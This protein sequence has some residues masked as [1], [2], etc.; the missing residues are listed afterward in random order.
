VFT[1]AGALE[2]SGHPALGQDFGAVLGGGKA[3]GVRVSDDAAAALRAGD[4]LI[5][6][7]QPQPTLEHLRLAR[8]A[9]KPVVIGTTGLSEQERGA[10]ADAAT[11]IPVVFS[12]NMSVGVNLLFELAQIAAQ[13]LGLAYDVEV[14][15]AHHKHKK[16][17]PSGTAKRLAE[18]VA[19]ARRQPVDKIPVHAIR[20]GDIVG[21]HTAIF[22]G[23][24]ERLELTHRASSRDVFAL[25]A[26]KA[27]QFIV[28]Q[29]SG[30]YDM[31]HV[32][33]TS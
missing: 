30:L 13:R 7:T 31:S 29:K 6:F 33:K 4:V 28:K 26:L 19:Q 9:K 12:P 10:I 17:S 21:D 23:P 8:A 18:A 3:L 1:V 20:A 2:A 5:E 27:A 25:G 15:E 14:V 11:D 24:Y 32:L 22:A 16:D